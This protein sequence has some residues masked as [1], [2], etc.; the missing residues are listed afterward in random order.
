MNADVAYAIGRAVPSVVTPGVKR[1]R[2]VI[3][4]DARLSSPELKKALAKGLVESGA[5]VDDVGFVSTPTFYLVSAKYGYDGGIQV[6]ASHN[7]KHW[8]GFK[9]VGKNGV[10]EIGRA[11]CR[12]R[13]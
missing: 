11:S 4:S 13:V 5:N 6:S 1:P 9:I 10:P 2:F 7:P 3:G 8:N 12:E